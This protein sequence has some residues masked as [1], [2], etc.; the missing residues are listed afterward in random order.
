MNDTFMR[1]KIGK[2]VLFGELVQLLHVKSKKY[3]TVKDKVLARDERENTA[4]CLSSDGSSMSW[5]QLLPRYKIDKEGDKISNNSE[6]IIH[7]SEKGQDHVHCAE[8]VHGH[9]LMREV[10]SS[11]EGVTPWRISIY[12]SAQEKTEESLMCG[13]SVY[14][15]S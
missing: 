8:R 7:V 12:E 10:N 4:I 6:L 11:M 1:H 15:R 3:V 14:Q 5:L 2:K 13:N 9:S